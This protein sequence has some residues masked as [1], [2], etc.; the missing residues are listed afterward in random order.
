M[1]ALEPTDFVLLGLRSM[2]VRLSVG[3]SGFASAIVA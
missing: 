1:T 2:H 3:A